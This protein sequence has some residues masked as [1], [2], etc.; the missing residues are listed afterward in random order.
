M[1]YGK[2]IWG[3]I[4]LLIALYVFNLF[5]FKDMVKGW[6]GPEAPATA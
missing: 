4:F 2:W 1:K 3:I 6:F 5:G